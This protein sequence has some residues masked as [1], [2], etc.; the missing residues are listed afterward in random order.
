MSSCEAGT[1]DV[2]RL[3]CTQS[4][5]NDAG[6]ANFLWTYQTSNYPP[7][8]VLDKASVNLVSVSGKGCYAGHVLAAQLPRPAHT[9]K[10]APSNM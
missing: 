3:M 4:G 1:V 5:V 8:I 10:N 9:S 6:S 7:D 2:M